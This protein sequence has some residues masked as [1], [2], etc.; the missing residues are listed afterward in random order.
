MKLSLE[1][2]LKQ[3]MSETQSAVAANLRLHLL[4]D[5]DIADFLNCL[6]E[7]DEADK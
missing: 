4:A 5:S 6:T 3:S 7:L 1:D 2:E